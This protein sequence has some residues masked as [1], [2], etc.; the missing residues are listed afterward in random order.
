MELA[1]MSILT[2]F[3]FGSFPF[4]RAVLMQVSSVT[5]FFINKKAKFSR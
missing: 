5:Y 3:N 2:T 1:W 4:V